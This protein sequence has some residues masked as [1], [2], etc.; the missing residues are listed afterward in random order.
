MGMLW[1][2]YAH[3]VEMLR[4]V[5]WECCGNDVGMM[6]EGYGNDVGMMGNAGGMIWE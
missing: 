4:G 3:D 6:W 5:T 1:T 2:G